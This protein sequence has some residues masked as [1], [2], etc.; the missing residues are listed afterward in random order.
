MS[1]PPPFICR[2]IYENFVV[3]DLQSA[4]LSHLSTE[5]NNMEPVLPGENGDIQNSLNLSTFPDRPEEK[6][7]DLKKSKLN[8]CFVQ[9]VNISHVAVNTSKNRSANQSNMKTKQNAKTKKK[10]TKGTLIIRF[11]L[12]VFICCASNM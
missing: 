3:Q 11:N 6:G 10:D 2:F 4:P 1:L 7:E 8:S 9:L 12:F 5:D